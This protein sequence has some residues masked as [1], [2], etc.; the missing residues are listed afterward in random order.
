MLVA[1]GKLIFDSR[2]THIRMSAFIAFLTV[3][4]LK[5]FPLYVLTKE[6]MWGEGIIF[7]KTERLLGNIDK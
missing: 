3:I 2:H 1:G 4:I 5:C 6:Y 7:Y